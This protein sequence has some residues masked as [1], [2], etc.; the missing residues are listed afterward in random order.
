MKISNVVIKVFIVGN[1]MNTMKGDV[2]Y[3]CQLN[4]IIKVKRERENVQIGL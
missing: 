1:K 4:F 3:N 2:R